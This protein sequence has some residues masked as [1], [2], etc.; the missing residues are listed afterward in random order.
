M[1]EFIRV[2]IEL[3]KCSGLE[4]CGKCLR[5]CPVNV[6]VRKGNHPSI[7]QE[8]QDKCTLCGLCTEDCAPGAITIRKLYSANSKVEKM[9]RFD[10]KM[11]VLSDRISETLSQ[12]ILEGMFKGG[13]QLLEMKLQEQFG[14]SRSPLREAFRNLEKKGLVVIVPRKGTFVKAVTRKDIEDNFPVRASLEGLAARE[15]FG[16]MSKDELDAME[17]SLHKMENA[18]EEGDGRA[19][20]E[21]H[22]HFHETFIHACGNHVLIRILENL[23]MHSMWYRFCYQYYKED[24][25]KS[26][27]IHHKILELFKDQDSDK[28]EI[29]DIVQRHIE[30]AVERFLVYL[31]EQK[32]S[33]SEL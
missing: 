18:A 26:L 12:A 17:Q 13:E 4:A 9:K 19:F 7:F 29:Q 32:N 16:K 3:P 27:A 31:K 5:V 24:F 33:D 11:E 10:F 1:S 2:E 15:A 22:I 23:R 8:N 14:V 28:Q 20:L 30:V 21:Y 6:F 25:Q